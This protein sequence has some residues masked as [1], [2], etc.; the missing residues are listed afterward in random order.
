[1]LGNA[2]EFRAERLPEGELPKAGLQTRSKAHE[3]SEMLPVA[4]GEVTAYEAESK[5][6]C[7]PMRVEDVSVRESEHAVCGL[8]S[9]VSKLECVPLG[10]VVPVEQKVLPNVER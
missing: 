9:E 2:A 5:W 4:V 3:A 1:M 7:L 8:A 6:K 10:D